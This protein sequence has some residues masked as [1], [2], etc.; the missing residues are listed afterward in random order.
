MAGRNMDI[1]KSTAIQ[2]LRKLRA[3]D[4]FSVV[5]FSD[6]AEVILPAFRTSELVKL[7]A[8]IQMLQTSGGTEIYQGL[9]AGFNEV[10]RNADKAHV[11]HIILL[12]D[13]RTYGDESACMELAQ[14]AANRGIGISGLGIGNEWNDVFLDELASCTGGSSMY[15]SRPDDIQRL[16]LE[17]F[18]HL[19]QV[20]AEDTSL[21]FEPLSGIVLRIAFRLQPEA[22]LLS[23][24]SPIRP[25]VIPRDQS[26][27]ILMEFFV[28]P[29]CCQGNQVD[30]MKGELNLQISTL[31]VPPPM[32]NLHLT[33]PI[34]TMSGSEPPPQEIIDAVSQLTLYR[35][36]ERA[37]FEVSSGDYKQASVHLQLLATHLLSQGKK[38]LAQTALLEAEHILKNQA[39]SKEGDKRIKYGTRSLLIPNQE[40]KA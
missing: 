38:Q 1:V 27:K 4:I 25:G 39:F 37:R 2:I 8:R 36:Q 9:E 31:P 14:K 35:L 13:G 24:E 22:G 5:A 33:R 18:N 26:I 17:K 7:E 40:K 11:N 19:W 23:L 12:T 6:R 10:N 20:Y 28:K 34:T 15:V 16:L 30:L 3:Q 32:V 29:E 21:S